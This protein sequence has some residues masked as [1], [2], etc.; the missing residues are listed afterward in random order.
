MDQSARVVNRISYV[1]PPGVRAYAMISPE[2]EN[3]HE[4]EGIYSPA[5]ERN[6]NSIGNFD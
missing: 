3:R 5:T 1:P 2:I 4:V 6:P